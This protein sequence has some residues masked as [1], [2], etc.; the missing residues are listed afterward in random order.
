MSNDENFALFVKLGSPVL[1]FLSP[2]LFSAMFIEE[3]KISNLPAYFAMGVLMPISFGCGVWGTKKY[4]GWVK[5][6]KCTLTI[7]ALIFIF[8]FISY[9]IREKNLMINQRIHGKF[10]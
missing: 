4:L 1:L 10:Q 7:L 2:V 6:T 5:S 9:Q 8:S 3:F